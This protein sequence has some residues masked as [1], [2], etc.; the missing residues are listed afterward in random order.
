MFHIPPLKS[1]D[2][3]KAPTRRKEARQPG[4]GSSGMRRYA[5][6]SVGIHVL[7]L[8]VVSMPVV[9][10][11][12]PV[13]ADPLY[14]VALIEWPEPNLKPPTPTPRKPKVVTEKPKPKQKALP[15]DAVTIPEKTVKKPAKKKE[16]APEPEATVTKELKPTEAA[17]EPVS[18]GVVD[19]RDFKQDYYLQALRRA[20]ARKW[21]PPKEGTGLLHTTLHFIV[22]K[23]GTIVQPKITGSSGSGLHDRAAMSAV[24][25]VK[26]PPLPEGYDGD[27]LGLT[28]NFKRNVNEP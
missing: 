24:L 21:H 19:Q 17:E 1:M 5:F 15:K 3:N 12:T 8:S 22:Q 4:A 14:E 13:H 10:R 27:H 18:L 2:K 7:V 6:S 25:S 23:D 20:L 28:V 16:P 11:E 9:Q 26:L